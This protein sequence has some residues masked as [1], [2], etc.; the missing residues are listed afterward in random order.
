MFLSV[1]VNRAGRVVSCDV[2]PENGTN[3]ATFHS[4]NISIK[5]P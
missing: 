4:L 2:F 3:L 1:V 5:M